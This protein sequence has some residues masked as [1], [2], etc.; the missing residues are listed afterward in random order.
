MRRRL[1]SRNSGLRIRRGERRAAPGQHYRSRMHAPKPRVARI[2]KL[3]SVL[4][5]APL[6]RWRR[7]LQNLAMEAMSAPP[8]L[9]SNLSNRRNPGTSIARAA[10]QLAILGVKQQVGCHRVGKASRERRPGCALIQCFIDANVG[11]DPHALE[12]GRID[13]D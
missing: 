1:A 3:R 2:S 9:P 11:G 4:P 12:V 8:W 10:E 6:K 5:L 13:N 7:S